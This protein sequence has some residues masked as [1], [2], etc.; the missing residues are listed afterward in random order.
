MKS[1]I[2]V[3]VLFFVLGSISGTLWAAEAPTN[4]ITKL[5]CEGSTDMTPMNGKPKENVSRTPLTLWL[6]AGTGLAHLSMFVS[7]AYDFK[8]EFRFKIDGDLLSFE[9]RRDE[10]TYLDSVTIQLDRT[11]GFFKSTEFYTYKPDPSKNII[12]SGVYQCRVVENRLF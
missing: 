7:N 8:K 5:F 6:D 1:S 11:T 9:T 4:V 12:S 2:I 10:P 3:G